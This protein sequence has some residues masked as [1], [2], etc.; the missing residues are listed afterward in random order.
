M[1]RPFRGGGVLWLLGMLLLMVCSSPE[2][3]GVGLRLGSA[4]VEVTPPI[5]YPMEGCESRKEGSTGVHDPLSV[6]VLVVKSAETSLAFVS[7]DLVG[8]VSERVVKGAKEQF[9]I[10]HVLISSSHT[11]AG[12]RTSLWDSYEVIGPDRTWPTPENSWYAATEE[13]I[14]RALGEAARQLEPVSLVPNTP[15]PACHQVRVFS[16]AR[17]PVGRFRAAGPT[18]QGFVLFGRPDQLGNR[19]SSAHRNPPFRTRPGFYRGRAAC[20]LAPARRKQRL[21]DKGSG[22]LRSRP[23]RMTCDR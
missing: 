12:P 15:S 4:R 13:K 5:G 16:K 23:G 8:F 2:A 11:H 19:A 17:K 3:Q 6:R 14:L 22:R 7:C 9:G 1:G 21:R 18:L 20:R 10:Q